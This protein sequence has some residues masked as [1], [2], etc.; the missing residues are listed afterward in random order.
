MVSYLCPS[1]HYHSICIVNCNY[2]QQ[3]ACWKQ[4]W[5]GW[6]WWGWWIAFLEI[7][8]WRLEMMVWRTV[9]MYG[10]LKLWWIPNGRFFRWYGDLSVDLKDDKKQF[11]GDISLL[12][13]LLYLFSTDLGFFISALHIC[14]SYLLFVSHSSGIVRFYISQGIMVSSPQPLFKC[15]YASRWGSAVKLDINLMIQRMFISPSCACCNGVHSLQILHSRQL[16]NHTQIGEAMLAT[17]RRLGGSKS[18]SLLLM[19]KSQKS[20]RHKRVVCAVTWE[21]SSSFVHVVARKVPI[22][23]I[24]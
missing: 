19:G 5:R 20:T 6:R 18:R 23:W 3:R 22:G 16:Y 10:C 1:N 8:D 21:R 7:E 9:C 11:Q 2:L 15:I 24:M 13:Y 17:P 12:V 14:S 4:K